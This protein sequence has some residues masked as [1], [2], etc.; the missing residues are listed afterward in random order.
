MMKKKKHGNLKAELFALTTEYVLKMSTFFVALLSGVYI[1]TA[2]FLVGYW[3]L[4]WG[5]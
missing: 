3:F 2:V 1:G 5:K 4:A